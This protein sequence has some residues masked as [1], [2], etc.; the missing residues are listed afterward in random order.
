MPRYAAFLRAMNVGGRRTT[1]EELTG[2]VAALGYG[3]PKAFLASGNL[4][5]DSTKRSSK[6]VAQHLR[7]GLSAALDYDVPAIV[8]RFDEL[9]ALVDFA[10]FAG[11]A[12]AGKPQL[13][14]LAERP[15]AEQLAT[16]DLLSTQDDQLVVEGREI[17]W[18]PSG[19]LMDSG[20]DLALIERTVGPVTVR[21][22]R[23]VERLWS[24]FS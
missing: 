10:P 7:R 2:Y 12:E 6:S 1:N 21:T 15:D 13:I 4:V 11:A 22:R 3:D 16:L 14:L 24:R 9:E 20:L 19:G 18:L 23:T 8:R 17:H 5:F